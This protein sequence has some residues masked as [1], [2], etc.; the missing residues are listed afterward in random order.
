VLLDKL[1]DEFGKICISGDQDKL[2]PAVALKRALYL[3]GKSNIYTLCRSRI[4]G[5]PVAGS[6]MVRPSAP[7]AISC[8]TG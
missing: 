3:K 2:G 8:T 7:R 4:S 6:I 1:L 5:L